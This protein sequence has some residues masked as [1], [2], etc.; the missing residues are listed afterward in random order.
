MSSYM[1][2]YE[3]TLYYRASVKVAADEGPEEAKE[4]FW[5]RYHDDTLNEYEVA[6]VGPQNVK[7]YRG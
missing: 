2:E 1:V 3:V 6:N 5:L 7:V 4:Q